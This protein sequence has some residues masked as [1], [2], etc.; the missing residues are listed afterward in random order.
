MDE[1]GRY[2][3]YNRLY[4]YKQAFKYNILNE[5]DNSYS[6]Q[7]NSSITLTANLRYKATDWLSAQAIFSYSTSNTEQENYLGEQTWYAASL[8]KSEYGEVP[9]KGADIVTEMPYGE[10]LRKEYTRNNPTP[11]VY[12]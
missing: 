10:E 2:V 8:R 7:D 12:K 5:L 3:Y 6:H 1:Q 9:G 4:S 11:V